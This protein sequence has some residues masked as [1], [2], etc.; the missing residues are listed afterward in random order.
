MG[1]SASATIVCISL[2]AWPGPAAA[3]SASS[4]TTHHLAMLLL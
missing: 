2:R 1:S 3:R 4:A